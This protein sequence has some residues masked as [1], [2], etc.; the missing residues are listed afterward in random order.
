[1]RDSL[2][3]VRQALKTTRPPDK[4]QAQQKYWA[5]LLGQKGGLV[6][7]PLLNLTSNEKIKIKEAFDN[8]GLKLT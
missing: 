7:R 8:C 5:D 3:P 6:R 4:P 2:E 1:V